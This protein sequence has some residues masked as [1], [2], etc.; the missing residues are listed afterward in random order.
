MKLR[1][2][3]LAPIVSGLLLTVLTPSFSQDRRMLLPLK[4]SWLFEIGDVKS[5]EDPALDDSKW[6]KI[7]VPSFWEDQGYPGYDGYA[8]Y[9]KH[10]RLKSE[11]KDRV[12][13]LHLGNIDDVDEVYVNGHF[14]GFSGLFPPRYQTAY[15]VDRRYPLPQWCLNYAGDNVISVRVY[16]RELGGGLIGEEYGIFEQLDPLS[17]YQSL[18]GNWKIIEGDDFRWKEP[19]YDDA[20]WR[21]IAVPA[22]WETQ[23][24][25][26]YDGFAWYRYRFQATKALDGQKLILLVGKIDDLDEVYLNGELIGKTGTIRSG[27]RSDAGNEYLELRA[28][29][30][31]PGKVKFGE[32]NVLAVRVY[33]NMLHGGIYDGPIGLIPRE[34]YKKWDQRQHETGG[35]WWR[36]LSRWLR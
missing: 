30:L 36:E 10:V 35:R 27:T 4:G 16:D 21:T 34:A 31:L 2:A 28:Y 32:E 18:A 25:K 17:P 6:E 5:G 29:T 15:A 12:L 24:M 26:D 14:I 1:I 8:W 20:A 11:W 13:Y 33:D 9:R 22:Y 7:G 19:G 3:I 23:G